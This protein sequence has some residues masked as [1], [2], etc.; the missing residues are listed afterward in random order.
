[1]KDLPIYPFLDDIC[2]TL[3]QSPS[4][5]LVLTA[6]TAAGKSTAVPIALLRRVTGSIV[7]LEPRR[8]ATVAVATRIAELLGEECGRTAGYRMRLESRVSGDTRIEIITEAI[9]T[10]RLQKDPSL[11]GVSVVIIDEFHERSVHADLAL[12]FL[13]ETMVL[14]DDLYV[15]VMSATIDT[16]RVSA[17]LDAPFF[18]VPGRRWPVEIE[19]DPPAESPRG[20]VPSIEERCARA[21][22]RELERPDGG[23]ILAFL[24]GI[25]EIRRTEGLLSGCGAEVL[26]LHSSVPLTEQKKVLSGA[27]DG[28]RRIVLSSSIAETSLTVPDIRTVID[29]G[30]SRTGRVDART[31]MNAL[32][33]GYESVFSADQRAG[34][35]GR[36][37]PGRCVRLWA[38][39]DARLSE[40]PPEI[41]RTDLLSVVL[42]CA[43]WG[44]TAIDGLS[45]LDA[46][47]AGAWN[48]ARDLL[49]LMGA[50]D[51]DWHI[52]DLGRD[53]TTLGVHPRVA[54]VALAGSVALA[55]KY[56]QGA[57]NPDDER[58]LARDL[59]RRL[60]LLQSSSRADR[61]GAQSGESSVMALLAGFPDRIAFLSGEGAYQFPSGRI[62]SLSREV[63]DSCARHQRWIVA[64]DVD[65]GERE[66]RIRSFE[67]LNDRE[68]EAWLSRHAEERTVVAFSDG[69]Y[70]PG[71]KVIKTLVKAYGKI[72][73]SERLLESEPSDVIPAILQAIRKEGLSALP[74]SREAEAFL[75]R[76]RFCYRACAALA[77]HSG[78]LSDMSEDA[79]LASLESW[80]APFIPSDGMISAQDLLASLRYRT[81][82]RLVDSE[83][84][85]R[86]AL[87]NGLSRPLG[88]EDLGT[89][90]GAV[91]I[92][93]IRI[94]DLFGCGETP[95]VLGRPVL[96]RLLSPARR[97]VQITSDLAGF[98]KNTWPEVRKE[99]KGRYPKHKWPEDPFAP[100]PVRQ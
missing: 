27:S 90:E 2:E 89:G 16:E 64:P 66:G 81:D 91:P 30:L 14:R 80:L 37:A 11:E 52:T 42:E 3:I 83:A 20:R 58:R 74:W 53:M 29:S 57:G 77:R 18:R 75:L 40:P 17:Y 34:R 76:A 72:I 71:S 41:L 9:L 19:Y 62:A 86:I 55:A 65:A 67:P 7:M 93:E 78:K 48:A 22:R 100:F 63:R 15:I 92:L 95:L 84:P 70:S 32:E 8:I 25:A 39:H 1:M 50:L 59:E 96:L 13:R 69:R 54:A 5:F 60:S 97:P 6:E 24:P 49:A 21:A 51:R 88:Y 33:T 94:Q 82:A 99:M 79:L 26:A 4:R 43:L 12:A 36:T 85:E 28:A 44:V 68:A 35:A 45:W 10:R 98:W 46:P 73:L 47:N 38:E 23:S 56:S 87:P 31:G 61:A